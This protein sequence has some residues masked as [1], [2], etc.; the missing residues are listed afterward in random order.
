MT[1]AHPSLS[2]MQDPHMRHLNNPAYL[3]IAILTGALCN[4]AVHLPPCW[5]DAIHKLGVRLLVLEKVRTYSL[6]MSKTSK[7]NS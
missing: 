6:A 1:A 3:C 4:G 5:I 2:H 7:S